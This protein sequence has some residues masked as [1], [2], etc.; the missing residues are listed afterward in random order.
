MLTELSAA[1][2]VRDSKASLVRTLTLLIDK[3]ELAVDTVA[4]AKLALAAETS[5][6]I[7]LKPIERQ[8]IRRVLK[9]PQLRRSKR[10]LHVRNANA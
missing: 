3:T 7:E 2:N 6:A 10:E 9:V 8:K 4:T 1:E 5:V